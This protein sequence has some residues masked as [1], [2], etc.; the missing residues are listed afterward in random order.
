MRTAPFS[1]KAMADSSLVVFVKP[2]LLFPRPASETREME[3]SR[4]G[5]GGLQ[6]VLRVGVEIGRIV[7]LVQLAGGIAERAVDHPAALHRRA[8]GN[9]VGPALHVLV[10]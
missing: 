6:L 7:A 10:V 5:G 2:S 3:A 8:L 4:L 1:K 9:R